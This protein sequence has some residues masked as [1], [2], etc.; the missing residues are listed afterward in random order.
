[1]EAKLIE[2]TELAP[3]VRHFV[4]EVPGVE[5]FTF[6]PGQF[7]SM[8]R[9][10]NEKKITRAYSIAS[11]PSETNRFE[12][13]LNL[14]HEGLLSPRLFEMQPGDTVDIRP[15]LGMFVL[16]NPPRDT[17]FIATGTGI[18]PFRSILKAQL[19]ETSQAFTLVFGVRHESHLMYRAEFEEMARKYPNFRFLPTLSRPTESWSGRAGH[20]Q[21]HLPE[22]IGER[23][24]VDIFLCGLKLMV[25]DVRNILKEMG[26]DRKQILFEKYD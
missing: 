26:F 3:E 19:N 13:C 1:M 20:V 15:P 22:A 7:V 11:A 5:K 8:N 17:I 21:G 16:R 24:D 12:L 23:R 14:V 25:D 6:V 10:I 18:A 4:F 2:S 9:V